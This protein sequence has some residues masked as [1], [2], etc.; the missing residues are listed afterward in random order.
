M[1][2]ISHRGNIKG[3]NPTLEN[4]PAYIQKALH[5]GFSVEIDLR[6]KDGQLYL[7]H[8][9]PEHLIDEEFLVQ[10]KER[11]WV[12][13][14]DSEAFTRAIKLNLNCFWHNTDD[15]TMTKYGYVWC[16]PGK[17]PVGKLSVI[18]LPEQV[19]QPIDKN[20][21]AVCSDYVLDIKNI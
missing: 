14:K 12:H 7:G 15:Y 1:L 4:S 18:V 13:C 3:P 8:D 10:N 16:Y 17:E 5:S 6:V 21:F 9:Y 20:W 19:H 2:L 11:L